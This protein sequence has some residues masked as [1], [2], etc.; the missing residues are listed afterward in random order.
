MTRS[1]SRRSSYSPLL[2]LVYS[3]NALTRERVIQSLGTRPMQA[4]VPPIEFI[5][6]GT[7]AAVLKHA[8]TGGVDLFILDGEASPVGGLG[9]AKQLRDEALHCPL[10]V[11]LI[12]RAADEWLARWSRADAVVPHP[13]DPVVMADAVVPLLRSRIIA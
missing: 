11:V 9:L 12:G 6:V 3:D 7:V 2:V 13:I 10:V 5:E 1:Y 4:G 8:A